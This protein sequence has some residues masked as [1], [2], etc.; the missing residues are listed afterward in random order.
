MDSK[1]LFIR[2]LK[3]GMKENRTGYLEL[4]MQVKN[5]ISSAKTLLQ[6]GASRLSPAMYLDESE[7]P[8]Y[9]MLSLGGGFVAGDVY[10]NQFSLE[11]HTK[12]ILTTQAPNKIFKSPK[13][14]PALQKT[15]I[16]LEEGSQLEYISD[17]FIAYE[18][19]IYVQD[20]RIDMTES[21]SLV[22]IDGITS[23]WSPS[24][25]KFKYEEVKLKTHIYME[26]KP[27]VLDYLKLTPKNSKM[28]ALGMLEGYTQFGT[29]MVIDA[30]ITDEMIQ[31]MRASIDGLG[32]S[33]KY[34][35]STLEC[36]GFVL[37]VLGNLTQ[38]IEKVMEVCHDYVR[39]QLYGI[40]PLR[41]RKY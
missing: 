31:E 30:R 11:P 9:F 41:L 22:Y 14:V 29:M 13:Q 38:D 21:S 28:Q 17:S 18:D 27:V 36:K 32:K 24:G 8:C 34:G 33:I 19:A 40:E 4:V 10:E 39:D 35:L 25:E 1:E 26:G 23:G 7:I 16:H 2:G 5:G 20:T 37:R 3:L 6:K 12:A 15:L